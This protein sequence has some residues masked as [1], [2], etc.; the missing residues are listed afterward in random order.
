M[1]FTKAEKSE[2]LKRGEMKSV[3]NYEQGCSGE[4]LKVQTLLPINFLVCLEFGPSSP[5][6][7]ILQM[8]ER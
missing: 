2:K 8:H 3:P 4:T 7:D 5:F 1:W 6:I